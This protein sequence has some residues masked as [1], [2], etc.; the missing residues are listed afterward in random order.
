MLFVAKAKNDVVAAAVTWVDPI[1]LRK[2]VDGT[3]GQSS[4]CCRR[5]CKGS[6][7][8]SQRVSSETLPYP[9]R[10]KGLQVS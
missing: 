3:P 1:Q 2:A 8:V 9:A 5:G 4:T 7:L 6:P 10:L